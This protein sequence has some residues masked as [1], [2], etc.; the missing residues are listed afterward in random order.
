MN[1]NSL[2]S[3]DLHSHQIS[4]QQS[5]LGMMMEQEIHTMDVHLSAATVWCYHVDIDQN[6]KNVSS[7]N[8]TT[9]INIHLHHKV[10]LTWPW[11]QKHH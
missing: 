9:N 3:N 8:L 11:V 6:L 2:Y 5:S 10:N 7:R 4:V 1:T